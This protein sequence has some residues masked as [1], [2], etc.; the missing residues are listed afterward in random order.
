MP[1]AAMRLRSSSTSTPTANGCLHKSPGQS[2]FKGS[3]SMKMRGLISPLSRLTVTLLGFLIWQAAPLAHAQ[4][5][6]RV[7][8]IVTTN[9]GLQNRFRS[10]EH[11]SE[12]QSHSDLVCRLLLE[13][14]K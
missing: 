11:T 4:L 14:K 12:L 6:Y 5:P 13:K 1:A 3:E 10:E 2:S 8:D 7:G 9:F